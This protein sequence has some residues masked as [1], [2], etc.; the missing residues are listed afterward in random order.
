M[1]I[2]Q[3]PPATMKLNYETV[4]I[5]PHCILVPYCPEHVECYHAWMQDP[6][7]LIATGS[8]PLTLD[9]EYAMQQS[10][11][12]DETKCTFIV[13]ARNRLLDDDE[14]FNNNEINVLLGHDFIKRSM[15]AM[16]GDVNLFLSE[17][18]DEEEQD[19]QEECG[20]N[21]LLN[22]TKT[23]QLDRE[24]TNHSSSSSTDTAKRPRR[25]HVQA[26][27][28]IM[29]AEKSARGQGLGR[30]ACGLMMM[31]GATHLSIRRFF[32]KINEDNEASLGLFRH[33]LG[34]QQCDYAACFRQVELELKE[35]SSS[36]MIDKLS[37]MTTGVPVSELRTV[38]LTTSSCH[39]DS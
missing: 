32:C 29:I 35:Q 22:G 6:A 31:Y 39:D 13:L 33:K 34:F 1:A 4:L 25:R 23:S 11:R 3:P 14:H 7:L 26:E 15:C 17:E 12:D 2:I 21:Q 27:L 36:R 8:E 5:G 37:S 10:W 28:D 16:V 20:N 19:E 18:D 24:M 30:E 38:R 9:E